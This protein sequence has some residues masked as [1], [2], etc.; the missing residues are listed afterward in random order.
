MMRGKVRMG[1][2]VLTDASTVTS[3]QKGSRP[4]YF[5]VPKSYVQVSR[6]LIHLGAGKWR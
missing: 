6:S 4:R 1:S 3:A 2:R 5:R